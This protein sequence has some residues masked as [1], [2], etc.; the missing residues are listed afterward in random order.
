MSKIG[1]KPI[2]IP[3]GVTVTVGSD[4]IEVKGKNATLSVPRLQGVTAKIANNEVVFTIESD[5]KQ[6]K[7]NWGTL[8]AL[9]QN[10]IT[11]ATENFK[12]SLIIEGVGFRAALEGT[13][14]VMNLGFSHQIRYAIPQGITITIEKGNLTISGADKALVG[15]VAA[16]IRSYKKP[17]PYLGKGIR[18]SDEVIR[19]KVG[20]KAA[21]SK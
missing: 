5:T 20:K 1:K 19:R 15:Q 4:F 13:T 18:Y 16:K 14:L 9:T 2:T 11:G 17:E 12:K 8:R 10:A 3:E 6:V 21:T 7:S